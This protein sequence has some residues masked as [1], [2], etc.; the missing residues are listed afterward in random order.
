MTMTPFDL[1]MLTGI[2]VGGDPIPYDTDM[3]EWDAA[4][5]FL[6]G[7]RPPLSRPGMGETP[8]TREEVEHYARGFL[9][10][11]LGT[12]L[13]A[14]QANTVG[15]YLLSALVD[16]SRIWRYDWGGAGLATL[17][18]YMSSLSRRSR[19]LLGGY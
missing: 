14:D 4:Q 8:T 2:G 9:M 17:Y 13:F 1:S 11:L 16:L 6:L 5:I 3:G 10:F 15:L 7:T 19:H 12:T 18:G